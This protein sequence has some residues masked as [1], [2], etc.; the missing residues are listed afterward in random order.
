MYQDYP[1]EQIARSAKTRF[2]MGFARMTMHLMPDFEYIAFEACA[3][4][5]KILA[6][7]EIALAPPAEVLRRIHAD[8]VELEQ[9][10][11]R[12]LYD[13]AIREPVMWVRAAVPYNY[14]EAVV[15]ELVGRGARMEEVD[16]LQPQALIRARAPLRL[17]LGYP[18]T[19]ATLSRGSA[20]LR[21]WLSHYDPVP[22]APGAAA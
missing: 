2:Q 16:W 4:G 22:P 5:L 9:P 17:L 21:M 14:A 12:L 18:Q 15:Q 10:Q 6:M 13:T 8:E 20:Q 3:R 1:L 19:L 11:V 7:N